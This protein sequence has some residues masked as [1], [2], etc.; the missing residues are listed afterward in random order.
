MRR[1]Y[2]WLHGHDPVRDNWGVLC[3]NYCS[4]NLPEPTGE[5]CMGLPDAKCAATPL[6]Q[7]E[8]LR[9]KPQVNPQP[10]PP[11]DADEK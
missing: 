8:G 1:V 4:K 2:C 6:R 10:S 3:C 9:A 11:G 5:C 7:C